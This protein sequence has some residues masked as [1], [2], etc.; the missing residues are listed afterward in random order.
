MAASIPFTSID[1]VILAL[2][3]AKLEIERRD[4]LLEKDDDILF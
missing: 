3:K 1:D 2:A 4:G